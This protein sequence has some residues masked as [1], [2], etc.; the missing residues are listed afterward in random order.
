MN[1]KF[2]FLDVEDKDKDEFRSMLF[3]MRE[4]LDID[5]SLK[6]ITTRLTSETP[7]KEGC[8]DCIFY[9]YNKE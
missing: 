2:E 4:E 3:L 5:V 9:F 7:L 6:Y 8:T 1:H